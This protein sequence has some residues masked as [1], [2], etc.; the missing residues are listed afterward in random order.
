MQSD[1]RLPLTL[2][3]LRVG[4]FIVMF[5]WTIDKFARPEHASAVYS[6]WKKTRFSRHSCHPLS[7][8]SRDFHNGLGGSP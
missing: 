3:L 7:M 6:A 4:V 1:K 8:K 2:F 5:M